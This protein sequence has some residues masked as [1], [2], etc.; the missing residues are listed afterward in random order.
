MSIVYNE[1]FK[2]LIVSLCLKNSYRCEDIEQQYSGVT[3]IDVKEWV[4][5]YYEEIISPTKNQGC[6]EESERQVEML[7]RVIRILTE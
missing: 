3:D 4:A 7:R 6:L 5:T 1:S 2:K